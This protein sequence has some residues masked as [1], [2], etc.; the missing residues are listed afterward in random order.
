MTVQHLSFIVM[1]H[2]L[3]KGQSKALDLVHKLL[4]RTLL[5]STLRYCTLEY[6]TIPYTMPYYIVF[7]NAASDCQCF[8]IWGR[9]NCAMLLTQPS[10][11]SRCVAHSRSRAVFKGLSE[12]PLIGPYHK[13]PYSWQSLSSKVAPGVPRCFAERLMELLVGLGLE[14]LRL[15]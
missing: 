15:S 6:H 12:G 9:W 11:V 7:Y 10:E 5:Y 1:N 3:K 4:G 2:V 14:T 8:H 13:T